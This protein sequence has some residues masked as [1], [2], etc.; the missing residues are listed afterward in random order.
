[1]VYDEL[2]KIID[3]MPSGR[4]KDTL[5]LQCL[6]NARGKEDYWEIYWAT[7]DEGI[8]DLALASILTTTRSI[9]EMRRVQRY[10]SCH[11]ERLT[12]V[13]YDLSALEYLAQPFATNTTR[14]IIA[15]NSHSRECR[16]HALGEILKN[17]PTSSE[18]WT[19]FYHPEITPSM[20]AEIERMITFTEVTE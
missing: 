7:D 8:Q 5:L 11:V 1:V 13:M 20:K 12:D 17:S 4:E 14:L 6:I 15:N 2:W 19:L 18:L 9:D 3:L 10:A 16:H